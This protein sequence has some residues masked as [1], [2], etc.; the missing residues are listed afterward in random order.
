M[1]IGVAAKA[2]QDW[3]AME[4][5]AVPGYEREWVAEPMEIDDED[6]WEDLGRVIA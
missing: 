1:A 2:G 4:E 3:Q 5:I 6:D